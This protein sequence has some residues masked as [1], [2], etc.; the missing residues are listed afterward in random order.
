MAEHWCQYLKKI[1]MNRSEVYPTMGNPV[2]YAERIIDLRL[3][4]FLFMDIMM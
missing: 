3:K 2:V 4:R 1:G